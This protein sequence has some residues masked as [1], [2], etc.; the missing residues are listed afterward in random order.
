[1]NGNDS[2]IHVNN[3]LNTDERTKEDIPNVDQDPFIRTNFAILI[4][5]V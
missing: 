3:D 5:H 2:L 4:S 1:M